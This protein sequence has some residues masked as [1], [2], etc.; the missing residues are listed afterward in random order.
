MRRPHSNSGFTLVELLVVIAMI[1]L[2]ASLLLPALVSA[3][4]SARSAKCK[5]N[6]RQIG[7]GL[8]LYVDDFSRYPPVWL[9]G[10]APDA[11]TWRSLLVPYLFGLNQSLT[12]RDVAEL[13]HCPEKN[14][15]ELDEPVLA[16]FRRASYGYNS[17]GTDTSI[18]K[19]RQLGLGTGSNSLLEA[20]RN[21]SVSEA[22]VVMPV[23]MIA[24][25]CTDYY[26]D[27]MVPYPERW[28]PG[29]RHRSGC[30][31]FMCDGHVE[32]VKYKKVTERSNTA[33]SRWNNDHEAH[34]DTWWDQ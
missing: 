14:R 16:I 3:K 30:N 21:G 15:L 31:L 12:N 2:L 8:R 27:T 6:L 28:G 4:A 7:I 24:I 20:R 19:R 29:S 33:R 5:S 23:E 18:D 25:G 11:F 10:D 34:R 17:D 9:G 32:Y 1:A 22:A 13:F 26:Y